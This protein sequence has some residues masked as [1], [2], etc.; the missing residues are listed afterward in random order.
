MEGEAGAD[1]SERASC[2]ELEKVRLR[3]D[4][5]SSPSIATSSS[6][7][8]SC[9]DGGDRGEYRWG[10]RKSVHT[11]PTRCSVVSRLHVTGVLS[12]LLAPQGFTLDHGIADP[13]VGILALLSNCTGVFQI[14]MSH[15]GAGDGGC[16]LSGVLG[17]VPGGV[18]TPMPV[19]GADSGCEMCPS[20][21]P[22][23]DSSS[24]SSESSSS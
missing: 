8:S 1:T 13:G 14:S 12:T 17:C 4:R 7:A 18:S 3:G 24:G 20:S 16:D 6:D 15:S 19:R 9:T 10:V 2:D 22:H 5:G 11:G 21:Q 23:M